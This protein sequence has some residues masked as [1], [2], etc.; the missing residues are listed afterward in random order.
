[1]ERRAP[2]TTVGDLVM[3]NTRRE[4]SG[5]Y[6]CAPS[7][8]DSASVV[9][10]VLSG[11]QPAAMQ[12]GNAAAPRAP[13]ARLLLLLPGALAAPAELRASGRRLLRLLLAV[14]L[15][16]L[17][18][19]SPAALRAIRTINAFLTSA[20]DYDVFAGRWRRPARP[21]PAAPRPAPQVPAPQVP[22]PQVPAPAAPAPQVPAPAA[23]RPAP[24]LHAAPAPRVDGAPV[25][26]RPRHTSTYNTYCTFRY[27]ARV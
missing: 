10:H 15:A 6:S 18:P 3:Y 23:P 11:E 26:P 19:N 12:H 4:D 25:P 16:V 1:M 9:L 20:P 14:A 5:N 17:L 27:S 21:A 13:A 7:N 22:A 24:Q 2:D 8:L